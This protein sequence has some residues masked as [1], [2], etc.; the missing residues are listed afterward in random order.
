MKRT[1]FLTSIFCLLFSVQMAIGQTQKDKD[2]AAFINNTRLLSEKPF[3]EHAPAARRWNLKY[4]ADTDEVT[5][6][7]CSGLLNLVPEKKNKFKGEL[8]GQLMYEIGVFKLK[9][10]DQKDDEAAANLAGLE[11]ML[12]TYENMVAQNPKAKNTELDAM[13]AKRDKGE[14]KSLVDGIDCSKKK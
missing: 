12:R 8:F 6:S 9:N 1:I 11:G 5:V 4:L 10:P 13:V 7:I 14:L 2:R 3:D